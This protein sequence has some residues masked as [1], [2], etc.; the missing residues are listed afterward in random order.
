LKY[1]DKKTNTFV[2][3]L[4]EDKVVVGVFTNLTQLAKVMEGKNFLT[5]NQLY[6]RKN[7]QVIIYNNFTIQKIKL[8]IIPK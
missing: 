5:Y 2:Y 7:Q 4:L 1:S 6:Y 3:V 8:N